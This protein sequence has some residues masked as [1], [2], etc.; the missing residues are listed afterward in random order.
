MK[1]SKLLPLSLLATFALA[2]CSGSGS[3]S[4]KSLEAE[5]ILEADEAQVIYAKIELASFAVSNVDI[6]MS[7]KQVT[8]LTTEEMAVTGSQVFY[9][10]GGHK[11]TSTMKVKSVSNGMTMETEQKTEE[12][13]GRLDDE[14]YFLTNEATGPQ[15]RYH[16]AI[17]DIKDGD[18]LKRQTV[19]ELVKGLVQQTGSVAQRKDGT[20][21]LFK[22]TVN[23]VYAPVEFGANITREEHRIQKSQAVAELNADLSVKS[24]ESIATMESNID[25]VT[26]EV[27]AQPKLIAEQKSVYT[28]SYNTLGE[29]G[30]EISSRASLIKSKPQLAEARL[31]I[32]KYLYDSETQKCGEI[33]DTEYTYVVADRL[34]H[35]T[36]HV[37]I[38]SDFNIQTTSN[39]FS[40]ELEYA[41]YTGLL[42]PGTAKK[43]V[44][45]AS[46]TANGLNQLVV[47]DA[48]KGI[49]F[50][51]GEIN[52]FTLLLQFDLA[53][54]ESG[55]AVLSNV[56][57]LV[58]RDTSI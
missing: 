41:T 33:V 16:E 9:K 37:C 24:F 50:D 4:F 28:V 6:S 36:Y 40:V 47:V 49:L 45:S 21:Y 58:I 56:D 13:C 19:A 23:E 11:S 48:N 14:H 53:I 29:A 25:P 17:Y 32:N 15:E 43:E 38:S 57:Y 46:N 10:D 44:L 42:Q 1:I 5:K 26:K 7:M 18:I 8:A 12:Y 30:E 35:N 55:E 22:S 52:Y 27:F 54:N 34:S 51:K 20:Y 31:N 39:A 3:A 2:G